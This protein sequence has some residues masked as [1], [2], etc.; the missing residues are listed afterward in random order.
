MLCR[1]IAF[2]LVLEMFQA[3]AT[4]DVPHSLQGFQS[5][6][7]EWNSGDAVEQIHLNERRLAT[8]R[9]QENTKCVFTSQR[10]NR[11]ELCLEPGS[12]FINLLRTNTHSSDQ[13]VHLSEPALTFDLLHTEDS[14]ATRILA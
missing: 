13:A 14:V 9:G 7:L 10:R 11:Q 6:E 4:P 5:E 8:S 12:C 3:N 2:I 1:S